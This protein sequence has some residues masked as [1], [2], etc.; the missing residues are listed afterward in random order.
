MKISPTSLTIQQ[1]LGSENEQYVVPAYQRRYSWHRHQV[2]DL[3]DDLQGLDNADSHLFGTVVCLTE[4]HGARINRLELVDGQQRITTISVL[5]HCL[6]SRLRSENETNEAQAL[7]RLLEARGPGGSPQPKI[8]LDSLDAAQFHK[9][10]AGDLAEPVDNPRLLDAFVF[11]ADRLDSLP[12]GGVVACLYRLKNQ[13]LIIRLDVSEAKDAFKLFE[14]INN[15]GLRLSAT[16]I[17]KNFILGNAARFG[18]DGLETAK[19]RWAELLKALDGIPIDTFFRHF[20]MA[21]LARRVTKSEV[22]REFQELFMA[23]VLEAQSLPDRNHFSDLTRETDDDES[24]DAADDPD[25]GAD[26]DEDAQRSATHRER[27]PF[28]T[29]LA[30]LVRRSQVYRSLVA[31]TTGVPAL[32]RR[33][34]NLKLIRAQPSYGFLMSLRARGATDKVFEEVL[35]LTECLLLRRHTTRERT[36]ENET[37]FAELCAIDPASPVPHVRKVYGEHCPSDSSFLTEFAATTFPSGL[38][39]RARYCLEQFELAHQGGRLELQPGGPDVVHV[40]HIIPKKIKSKK[41]KKEL[42]DWV[43]YLGSKALSLHPRFVGRIG[44]L[45]L[46][47]GDLN[48]TASNN[49]YH[50]KLAC[51]LKSAFTATRALPGD[52]P[53]FTFDHVDKRSLALAKEAVKIWPAI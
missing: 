49:P 52:Y 16:D 42:G 15:R 9:H 51:Y 28:G 20:M 13:A 36:G 4:A 45:T 12:I 7:C 40:E 46:L 23:E 37:I 21:R 24:D 43:E 14:T 29:F 19:S 32:D 50:R 10:A 34:R 30:E 35:R 53:E 22:V 11:L 31:A 1:L 38:I 33:L 5:L 18:V 17:L 44:N 8:V 39:D 2:E 26:D 6:L 41:A 3:W 25:E 27:L 48:L 47:A